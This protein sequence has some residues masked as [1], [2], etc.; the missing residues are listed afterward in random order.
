MR[1]VVDDG[2]GQRESSV[3]DVEF[4]ADTCRPRRKIVGD[5]LRLGA[6]A[7]A[8]SATSLAAKRSLAQPAVVRLLSVDNILVTKHARTLALRSGDKV[9]N[10][11]RVALGRNDTGPKRVAGDGKTPEGLYFL[12]RF[13][14][15]SEFYKSIHISYPNANDW[16]RAAS[17][18]Q[19]PGSNI[20]L[21]GLD[22]NIAP[23]NRSVHWMF[24]WTTGCIAV[25][26]LEID[27]IWDSVRL[28]TPIEIRA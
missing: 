21:H 19:R 24:N 11:F 14:S 23:E 12:D 8:L 1:R 22:P 9:M 28:G 25:T 2:I 15:H 18:G 16:V 10:E 27:V 3:S 7:V 5:V 6:G 20:M 13:N 4:P 17:L 26:D